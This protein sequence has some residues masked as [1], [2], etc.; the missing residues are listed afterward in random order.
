MKKLIALAAMLCAVGGI[1]STPLG[2]NEN[3][4]VYVCMGQ[5]AKAYHI[6]KHCRGVTK[7]QSGNQNNDLQRGNGKV[8]PHAMQFLLQIIIGQKP[9]IR[10]TKK[11]MQTIMACISYVF[12]I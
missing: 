3:S 6:N 4:T 7:L 9:Y 5:Y 8:P 10:H 1:C 2:V 11:E 12:S